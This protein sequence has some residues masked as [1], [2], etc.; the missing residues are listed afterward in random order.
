ML[1]Q[2]LIKAFLGNTVLTTDHHPAEFFFS[3]QFI[4]ALSAYAQNLLQF[5]YGITSLVH[6]CYLTF[7]V[8]S[9][10]KYKK[11]RESLGK[12]ANNL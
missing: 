5:C 11:H 3:E 6:I 9:I 7:F 12:K 10:S 1:I 2:P 8:Y 4:N